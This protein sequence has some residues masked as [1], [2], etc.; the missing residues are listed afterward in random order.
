MTQHKNYC[1]GKAHTIITQNILDVS[2]C[3]TSSR[4]TV[5][6]HTSGLSTLAGGLVWD[7]GFVG[8][9]KNCFSFLFYTGNM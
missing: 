6:F 9:N 7:Q 2:D 4:A 8:R 1:V 3:L 5:A